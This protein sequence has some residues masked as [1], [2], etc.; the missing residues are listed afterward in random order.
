MD[1][2]LYG[3]DLEKKVEK[4]KEVLSEASE[5]FDNLSVGFTGGKDSLTTLEL[6]KDVLDDFQVI[7]VDTGQHFD[8]VYDFIDEV[9]EDIDAELVNATNKDVLKNVREKGIV[10]KEDLNE[11]NQKELEK[12]DWKEFTIADDREPCCH[13]LKTVA[14]QE[15]L[16][17]LDVDGHINGI[18]WDEQESRRNEDY[19]SER[20]T[21][22]R[23][24]PILHWSEDDVWSYI[25]RNGIK[26]NPM[27]DRGY[28]SLG[29]E[30]CTQK[31]SAEAESERAGRAQDKEKVMER[32]RRLGY[33]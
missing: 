17:N 31:V 10:K 3:L 16:N 14:F 15:T 5:E 19:F 12:I 6:V 24:H 18:R 9:M 29:C 26:Y 27:Y 7:F 20:D 22:T 21:H 30:P 4:S 23:V 8:E 1:E 28:R 33:M 32:L 11:L 2:E 13:L 25:K